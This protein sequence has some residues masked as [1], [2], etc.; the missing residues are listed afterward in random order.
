MGRTPRINAKGGRDHWGNLGPLLLSGGGLRP[1][2][3]I[4]RSTRDAAAPQSEPI[5]S[6]HLL[7][8]ILHT[9]FDVGQLRLVPNLP[10][11]FAQ[12]M[13]SY[14]GIPGLA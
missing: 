10:R 2:Q 7:A 9:L 14:E 5:T 3:V 1:G 8:T 4:G 11:E 6:R 13:A 12:D